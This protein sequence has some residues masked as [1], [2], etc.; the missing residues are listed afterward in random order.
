MKKVQWPAAVAWAAV[1]CAVLFAQTYVRAQRP[2]GIDLTSYLLSADVLRHGGSP[3]VLPTPF[4][5]LYPATLAFL[6]IPLT[7]VPAT[8]AVIVWFALSVAAAVWSIRTVVLNARPDLEARSADLAL[9]LAVFFTCFFTVA[10]SNLR[11]GQVNF[12]VLALCVAAAL[13]ADGGVDDSQR[14]REDAA[15]PAAMPSGPPL[16]ISDSSRRGWR[17]PQRGSRVGV[18]WGPAAGAK[19]LAGTLSWSLAVAIKLMPLA[20]FPYFMLRRSWRWMIVSVFLIVAWCL[21]PAVVVGTRIVDIYEQYWRVFLATSVAPRVQPLD[22]SLAG[23]IAW[24]TG[25]PLTPVLEVSGAAVVLGWIIAVDGRRLRVETIR[26][27]ALYLLAIPLVS[28]Q[29]EV[30]HLAFMLPAAAIV[31]GALWWDWGRVGRRQQISA[32]IAATLYLA[33]TAT[34]IATGPVFCASLIA[35]GVALMNVSPP[36][37]LEPATTDTKNDNAAPKVSGGVRL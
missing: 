21:L 12:I 14:D 33:A 32:A 23:T 18:P 27:L 34:P 25:A 10:Q 26:P 24:M 6:V 35:F 20:L 5:Y 29:S 13:N 31:A 37:R 22:F 9:L 8:V 4:P 28:P 1:L 30:H 19:K 36:G 11:N 15:A 17:G 16:G 3:Y 7:F 2:N